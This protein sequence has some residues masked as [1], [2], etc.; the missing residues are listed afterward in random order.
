MVEPAR[1]APQTRDCILFSTADWDEPYWTNKQHTAAML[2]SLGWR[3]LYIESVGMRAPRAGSQRDWARLWKRLWRGLAAAAFGPRQ[4]AANIWVLPPL[5][6]PA[7]HHSGWVKWLNRTL[8]QGAIHR[9]VKRQGFS[10][11]LVWTYHPYLHGAIDGLARRALIYHCVDDVSTIPGVDV[12]FFLASERA[13]LAQSDAAFATSNALTQRCATVNPNT[14]YFGNVVDEVHF[15]RALLHGKIP[16]DLA[17][18]PEPRIVYHGVLSD[19]KVDF[20]LLRDAAQLRPDWQWILIGQE[21]EGQR[22]ELAQQLKTL[23]NVHFL[24]YRAY[25]ALPD[26]LRGVQVGLL[27]T[28]LNDYTRSMFPMK[29]FEYLAAGVP[30]V[31]TRLAFTEHETHGI[32]VADDLPGFIAAIEKQLRGGRL[33]PEEARR[34]VGENTWMGRTTKMLQYVE[35]LQT[36]PL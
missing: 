21:R 28:V 9:F 8:L 11:P 20:A 22:S 24:G 7:R 17:C 13:L 29:Y 32:E 35:T 10:A 25:E 14:R 2:A 5:T 3:V 16:D 26:Y 33:T 6:F 15:G 1:A 4:R 12:D 34:F 31:S 19:F 23:P 18:L 30:V 36:R 27:P